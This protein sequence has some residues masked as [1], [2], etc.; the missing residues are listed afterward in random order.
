MTVV[1]GS[2]VDF[3]LR[4][5]A[6]NAKYKYPIGI[7]TDDD[8]SPSSI[9]QV[10]AFHPSIGGSAEEGTLKTSPPTFFEIRCDEDAFKFF[11]SAKAARKLASLLLLSDDEMK[12]LCMMFDHTTPKIHSKTQ[13]LTSFKLDPNFWEV[14]YET[15]GEIV[16]TGGSGVGLLVHAI[17]WNETSLTVGKTPTSCFLGEDALDPFDEDEFAGLRHQQGFGGRVKHRKRGN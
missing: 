3:S 17:V 13:H 5:I 2:T 7:N 11:S 4:R 9:V 8:G 6:L 10:L 1:S 16:P 14:S 12:D 15:Q